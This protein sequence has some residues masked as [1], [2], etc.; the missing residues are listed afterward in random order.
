[1]LYLES[2]LVLGEP[3]NF[4]QLCARDLRLLA[5]PH[6]QMLSLG[7]HSSRVCTLRQPLTP[8]VEYASILRS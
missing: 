3:L 5:D 8:S 4:Q 1:M 6:G 2:A 7:A